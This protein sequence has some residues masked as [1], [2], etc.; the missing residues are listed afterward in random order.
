MA[1][2]VG[3]WVPGV[4][5]C[6]PAGRGSKRANNSRRKFKEIVWLDVGLAEVYET[7]TTVRGRF[8]R[9]AAGLQANSSTVA[10]RLVQSHGVE[11]LYNVTMVSAQN[12]D[13]I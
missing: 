10:R 8:R 9:T 12:R 2:G 13:V 4:Q 11:L 1:H 7:T 5:S 3:G 6:R